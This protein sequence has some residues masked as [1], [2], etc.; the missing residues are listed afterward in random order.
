MRSAVASFA[1]TLLAACAATP[2]AERPA[3]EPH[4]ASTPM[5][6]PPSFLSESE[7]SYRENAIALSRQGRWSDALPFWEVLL[8]LNPESADYRLQFGLAQ[9][10]IAEMAAERLKAADRARQAGEID[11]AT[12]AYLRV[13]SV[14]PNNDAAARALRELEVERVKRA[15]L[16]RPPRVVAANR[17]PADRNNARPRAAPYTNDL[18]DLELGVMLF[19]QGD[20]AGSAQ[21]LEKYLQK[22]PKDESARAYLADAY[23]QLGLAALKGG[24]KE[25]ALGYLEKA[26]RL[27]YSDPAELANAI[28]SVRGALG[29]EYYRLG[30]QAFSSSIDKAIALWERSLYFDPGQTQAQIRLQQ[31]RRAQETLRSVERNKN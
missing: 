7:K 6:Q 3:S 11:Q 28:R 5:A 25:S 16:S 14:D 9:A 26:Q 29:D 18:G 31:A 15:Y 27:G 1:T 2:I 10:R 17:S 30:V 23:Q 20:H 12:I 8:L 13:L 21:S 24:R 22:N 4:G 19:K